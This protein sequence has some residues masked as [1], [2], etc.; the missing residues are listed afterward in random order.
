[1]AS[2]LDFGNLKRLVEARFKQMQGTGQL[3]VSKADPD[4]LYRTYLASFPDGT[5]PIFR[6]RAEHDCSACRR[7]IRQAGGVLTIINNELVSI[8]DVVTG[9][10]YQPVANAMSKLVKDAGIDTIYLNYLPEVGVDHHF[11]TINGTSVKWEHFYQKLDSKFVVRKDDLGQRTGQARTNYQTL[12]RSLTEITAEAISI[13]RDLIAQNILYRGAEHTGIINTLVTTSQNYKKAENKEAFLW[14]TSLTLGQA[15]AFRNTV[16][17]TLLTDISE[18]VDL[19]VAV[20][21]FEFKVAPENYKRT[22]AIIT[23]KMIAEA[24]AKVQELG[25]EQSLHRRF[26]TIDDLNINNVLF[27]SRQSAQL[28]GA[29]DKLAATTADT[30]P[31]LDK[32]TAIPIQNFIDEVIPT[33]SKI[34]VFL[35]SRHQ[36]NLVSLIAPVYGDAPNLMKWGNNFS[37]SYIG[38]VTDAIKERVKQA[39]GD[40]NGY[41]R[42]S[43]SWFNYDDLD[44]HIQEPKGGYIKFSSNRSYVTDGVL[45]VDMNAGSGQTRTPVENVVWKRK[46]KMVPGKYEVI[47]NCW[48]MRETKDR[49]FTIQMENEGRVWEFSSAKSPSTGQSV[50][51]ATFT[52]AKDGS[53]EVDGSSNQNYASREM[54]GLTTGK[55]IEAVAIMYSPNHWVGENTGNKHVFFMLKDC[56]NPEQARGFYNEFLG[57]ELMPHR[58]VFEHLASLLKAQETDQQ[59]SGLGFST[60]KPDHLICKVTGTFTRTLKVTF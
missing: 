55:F 24:E 21:Q 6:E 31:S 52:V 19:E 49:G 37:W 26:A 47:V 59:L 44:L 56:I 8:W 45:D 53:I 35:E 57:N 34:E 14:K 16:I 40:V 23:K 20:K 11:E 28:M 9:D 25:L 18:G 17:G 10:D 42:A 32:L 13:V 15:S 51:V 50:T 29:F 22:T 36:A 12:K 5:N 3:F 54:W 41:M 46:D 27:A 38:E 30:V 43:L 39:G 58:K 2:M 1:M 48:T 4:E 33:A 60:T 7:F